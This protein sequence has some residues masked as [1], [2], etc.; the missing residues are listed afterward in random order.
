M[1]VRV[2]A[3]ITEGDKLLLVHQHR[4]GRSYWTLPGGGLKEFERVDEAL[5]REVREETGLEI[6]PGKILFVA[7]AIPSLDAATERVLNLIFRGHVVGGA[8]LNGPGDQM[9]EQKD[10]AEFVRLADI[11][12]LNLLP[13]IADDLAGAALEGFDGEARYLGDLWQP[14]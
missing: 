9:D 8:L 2:S 4:R 14:K 7:D 10:A 3:V 13:P 1:K 5:V 11:A 12:S 6:R